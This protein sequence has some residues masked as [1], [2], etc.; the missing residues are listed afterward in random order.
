MG[1]PRYSFP[2]R[3]NN[4]WFLFMRVFIAWLN[5][6]F[7]IKTCFIKG[8]SSYAKTWMQFMFP[9]YIWSTAGVM[10]ITAHYSTTITK[11]FGSNCVQVLGTLLLLSY[12]KLLR[13][14]ITALVPA[15]LSVY[16][17]ESANPSDVKLVW[18]F[19][20][21]LS[22]CK[23]SAWIPFCSCAFNADMFMG[24]IHCNSSHF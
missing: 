23:K 7:G 14:I 16:P 22:Y 18:A 13:A 2:K 15:V 21:N 12:A 9:I 19:D 11:L 20:G 4:R 1:I 5:L 24:A 3:A 17:V 8:M 10:I 6:D